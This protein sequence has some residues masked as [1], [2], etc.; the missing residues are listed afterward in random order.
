MN[1]DGTC[2]KFGLQAIQEKNTLFSCVL[3]CKCIR[4]YFNLQTCSTIYHWHT[5]LLSIRLELFIS[6]KLVV[7]LRM[8]SIFSSNDSY[9]FILEL[10]EF[11][12]IAGAHQQPE[13]S[14]Y[15]AEGQ[16]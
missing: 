8:S 7:V 9:R 13:Q 1:H 10:I 5:K 12:S 6:L 11:F 14:N 2:D 3:A 16:T 4:W 15:L